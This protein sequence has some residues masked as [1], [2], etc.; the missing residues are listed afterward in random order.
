MS[1]NQENL[2]SELNKWTK[3]MLIEYILKRTIPPYVKLSDDLMSPLQPTLLVLRSSSRKQS[4]SQVSV[5]T[6]PVNTVSSPVIKSI[7]ANLDRPS[8]SQKF[9]VGTNRKAFAN[10]PAVPVIRFADVFVFRFCPQVTSVQLMSKLFPN[11]LDVTVTQMG[12][13]HPSYASFHIRLPTALLDDVLQPTF[14]PEGIS[15]NFLLDSLSFGFYQNCRGLRT[16]INFNVPGANLH[17]FSPFR[18]PFC[19]TNYLYNEP[20]LSIMILANGSNCI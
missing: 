3:Q 4:A 7:P 19:A 18:V 11:I 1:G 12:T 16:N 2:S 13:K 9:T 10:L 6:D 20:I 15:T 8:A 14:W 5:K 17:N